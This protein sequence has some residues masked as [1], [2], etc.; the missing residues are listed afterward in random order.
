MRD[1]PVRRAI[2]RIDNFCRKYI[3]RTMFKSPMWITPLPPPLTAL[4]EGSHGSIL[5]GN[6]APTRLSS[7]WKSRAQIPLLS[8]DKPCK[9]PDIRMKFGDL[10]ALFQSVSGLAEGTELAS[11]LLRFVSH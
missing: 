2:S 3:R 8:I 5:S 10:T 7:E 11:N 6:H 1:R 4:E 9:P